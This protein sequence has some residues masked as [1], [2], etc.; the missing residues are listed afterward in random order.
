MGATMMKV[1]RIIWMLL[2]VCV[3]GRFLW[4]AGWEIAFVFGR[5][6]GAQETPLWMFLSFAGAFFFSGER[7]GENLKTTFPEWFT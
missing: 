5:G 1:L 2:G 3:M 6:P 7:F 4:D